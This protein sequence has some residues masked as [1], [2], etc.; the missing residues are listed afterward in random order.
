MKLGK[1]GSFGKGLKKAFKRLSLLWRS[2]ASGATSQLLNQPSST[3]QLPVTPQLHAASELPMTQNHRLTREVVQSLPLV[4]DIF[5]N[6]ISLCDLLS[7]ISASQVKSSALNQLVCRIAN[8]AI[9]RLA[10]TFTT[11]FSI[12]RKSGLDSLPIYALATSSILFLGATLN[13]KVF[14]LTHLS[15]W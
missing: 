1:K 3:S 9:T 8:H 4:D 6:I 10:N 14:Q 11:L 2:T 5:L 7:V 12:T 15:I 13:L